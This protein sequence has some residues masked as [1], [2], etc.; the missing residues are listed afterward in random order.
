MSATSTRRSPVADLAEIGP[1]RIA[2]LCLLAA[3][4]ALGL[5]LV[6]DALATGIVTVI[7]HGDVTGVVLQGL[8]GA[9]L[10]A[11]ASWGL[12]TASQAAATGVKQRTRN[13][14]ARV[15]SSTRGGTVGADATLASGGLDELDAY[16]TSYLP[17]LVGAATVPLLVGVRILTADWV[18]ALVIVITV[19]LIPLFMALIGM[20]T[21]DRVADSL[22]ALGRLSDHLVELARGLP[23]LVG[24]GRDR[25]QTAAL[26]DISENHRVRSMAALRT[27]F[28]SALALDLL[29]TISVAVVAVFIGV[30][31]L[32]GQLTLEAGLVALILAPECYAPLREVGAAFHASDSGREALRRARDLIARPIARHRLVRETGTAVTVRRLTVTHAGRTAPAIDGLGFDA[33]P[34][35]VTLLAGDSGAGKSTVLAVLGNRGAAL[36]DDAR[37]SGLVRTPPAADTAFMPQ[38]PHFSSRTALDEVALYAADSDLTAMRAS[39]NTTLQRAGLTGVAH[40]DPASLSP[41]EARR[42]AFARTLAAVDAG[43]RLVLLDEPTAHLDSDSA[44]LVRR[45]IAELRE[46]ATVIVSSHDPGIR[47]LADQV[48]PVGDS[49]ARAVI[50]HSTLAVTSSD[51]A[52]PDGLAHGTRVSETRVPAPGPR[53]PTEP[54]DTPNGLT[55]GARPHTEKVLTEL[56]AF[57]RPTRLRMVA[58]VLV[59]MLAG[60]FAIALIAVSGWLIVK[61]SQETAIMYLMVAIVGVRFF[62]I[63]RS[64]LRYAERL[65]T[66][67]AVFRATTALRVRLWKALAAAGPAGRRAL[68]PANAL[69][70]LV[71]AADRVRDLVPRVVQPPLTALLLLAGSTITLWMLYPPAAGVLLIAAL[72][73][74]VAAP[75]LAV[76]AGRIAAREGEAARAEVFTAFT[77]LLVARDD[78]TTIAGERLAARIDAAGERQ[79]IADRRSARA[80]GAAAALAVLAC[81]AGA[82]AMLPITAT[83]VASG[84]LRA[85]LVAVLALVPLALIEPVLDAVS[86]ASKAPALTGVLA[87]VHE[88]TGMSAGAVDDAE[89]RETAAEMGDAV[90]GILLDDVAF[91]Y[92]GQTAPVFEHVAGGARRGQWLA[93]TGPSGSGKST[94]L[95]LLMRFA[96][97]GAG[98]YLLENDDAHSTVDA[99]DIPQRTLRARVAWCPQEGHL[100]DSTLRANLVIA[101]ERDDRPSDDEL[102]DVLTRVGLAS[103]V[104]ALPDGLDTRIGAAGER[105]SGG[106]RQRVAVARTLLARGDVVLV[107]EPTAQLDE[108]ASAALMADLRRAL[109]DRVAVL[110]THDAVEARA[111]DHV[112]VLGDTGRGGDGPAR[113][114]PVLS[115]SRAA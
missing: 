66:H 72:F 86:A 30:R 31:L 29:A 87:E 42:L 64:A 112:I 26:A 89:A 11:A 104:A 19:P 67:D 107:D 73:A 115:G 12:L 7:A 109:A 32:H 45:R 65:L 99:R 90:R 106:Q 55:A 38:H 17:S 36:D 93:I 97:P 25:E 39:A 76:L 98:R 101:R 84:D 43:A 54:T 85:E 20:H 68:S 27:A 21:R 94:L 34:H 113:R 110:V 15:L 14:L 111:A 50:P 1:R 41:G 9:L 28:L 44:A 3:I 52:S 8:V 10:R 69:A 80:E 33:R 100:F 96:D 105:L 5:V 114:E 58:A 35:T 62:G 24:L 47:L 46:R 71:G 74:L 57:V 59:G 37:C 78:L 79:R 95:A 13:R 108:Q 53:V 102:M 22:D 2:L 48:V 4:K 16:Y 61:A 6:A 75:A 83:A 23:V 81:C 92:P 63:G 77:D 91:A 56:A 60:A 18:S 88:V 40:A 49:D 103:E 51:A 70:S 82:V